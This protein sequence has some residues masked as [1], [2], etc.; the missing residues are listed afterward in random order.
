MLLQ[1]ARLG[2]PVLRQ[3]AK[4]LT[5]EG[6]RAPEVQRLIDDMIETMREVDGAGLAAP[7]VYVAKRI[8]VIETRERNP[9]YPDEGPVPLTV[10]INPEITRRSREMVEDWEG[11]L[12]LPELR[13]LV[14][15]HKAIEGKALNRQG[16]TIEFAAAGFSARVIQHESDHL[17]G[18][19]FIDRMKDLKSLG[20]SAELSRCPQ[21]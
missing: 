19:L 17:D 14:P 12:S 4:A 9:R 5:P 3:K 2:T 20:Y 6:V 21:D 7:Q 11:C 10:L 8:L 18:F 15:R 13:G 1:V 16:R